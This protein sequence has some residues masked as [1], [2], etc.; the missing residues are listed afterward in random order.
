[1][2]RAGR[3]VAE[4]H[5]RMAAAAVPGVT[6]GALDLIGREVLA[7]R[8]ARSNFLGYH[9]FPAV[10]CL[11]VNDEVV[12]GIPGERVLADGD[13]LS[14]DCG[15]I[16]DGWHGDAAITIGIGEISDAA[17]HLI[18]VTKTSLDEAIAASLAGNRVGAIGAAVEAVARRAKCGL[19]REY[20]GHGIGRAMHEVPDIPNYGPANRGVK[21]QVGNTIC[22]EPMLTAGGSA[23][24]ELDDGWT[25]VT[26]DGSLAAHWE[27]TVLVGEHGP[28]VLT[29][30]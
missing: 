26:N 22:I 27:H 12:H 20:T 2:R 29:A 19:V 5:E 30:P 4:M 11:S 18:E 7:V 6:T 14:I 9:G 25:V 13:V 28:E 17:R 1:M 21:L 16:V 23:V 3:V 24:S 10:A 8:G 15:A